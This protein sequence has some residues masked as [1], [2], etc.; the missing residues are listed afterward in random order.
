MMRNHMMNLLNMLKKYKM[1]EL[2]LIFE[3]I[4]GLMT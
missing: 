3:E 2:E 1:N 4:L